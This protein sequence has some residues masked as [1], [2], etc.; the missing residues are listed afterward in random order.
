VK[1]ACPQCGA[2]VEFRFDDTFVR[3]C[4]HCRAACVRGDRGL[5]TLGAFADLAETQSPLALFAIG[6]WK[7]APFQLVGRAQLAHEAGGR[8]DEWYARFDDGRWGWLAEAQGRFYMMFEVEHSAAVAARARV[9]DELEIPSAGRMTVSE[10]GRATY[11][12]AAGEIPFRLGPGTKYDYADLSGPDGRF[13]TIDYS[14]SVPAIYAGWG[15]ALLDLGISGGDAG[16]PRSPDIRATRLACPNCA[17]SLELRAPDATQ[18]IGC[19]YCGALVDTSSGPLSVVA[20]QERE[21]LTIPLGTKAHFEDTILVV[22]GWMRRKAIIDGTG[23]PFEEYLLYEPSL[24]FRWLVESDGNWSYVKPVDAGLVTEEVAHAVYDGVRFKQFQTSPLTVDR[25]LGEMY[26]KV[27]IDETTAGTDYVAPPAMLSKEASDNEVNW[28]L[29]TYVSAS[30]LERALEGT[31]VRSFATAAAPNAPPLMRGIYPTLAA[32]AACVLLGMCVVRS[33]ASGDDVTTLTCTQPVCFSEPFQLESGANVAVELHGNVT[34]AWISV[35][36]DLVNDA[37]G[38]VES[39]DRDVEYYSGVDG[40]ESWSEGSHDETVFLPPVDDGRYVLRVELQ[41]ST[42]TYEIDAKVVQGRFH[43]K[44]W[45]YLCGLVLIPG[46]LLAAIAGW[47]E[48]SRWKQVS[49]D[50]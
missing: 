41:S 4:D 13:A 5:E 38:A 43:A 1:A 50:E 14:D 6:S 3:V 8:W 30:E 37:T 32:A 21:S 12:A 35:G 11:V 39:F 33:S 17:G 45:Y 20:K 10:V 23:Y 15:A 40:G 16:P 26:W 29:G 36:G 42:P 49:D 22:I 28:S 7:G 34:N 31:T 9:G 24:G 27:E 46:A 44:P 19:P 2:D 25:V 47:R 48:R 18:R